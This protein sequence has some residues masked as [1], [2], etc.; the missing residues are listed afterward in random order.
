MPREAISLFPELRAMVDQVE[1][2]P[3]EF[4]LASPTEQAEQALQ[5][6]AGK[7]ARPG[8]GQGFQLDQEVK[9]AVE[10]L[11]MNRA[12]EFYSQA[13]DVED[14][15]G[16]ES[17]DLICRR[18]GE[19]K[20]VEVKGTTTDGAEVILTPNEVRHAREYSH[21]ALFVVS[22]ITV[23]RAEDGTVTATGGNH[24]C[25]DPWRVGDGTLTPLGFRYQV[26]PKQA[27][28]A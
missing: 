18:G 2:Q 13:W 16:S 8:R 27:E 25:Y 14:V 4:A 9:V 12:T 3:S 10:A 23:G 26:P 28:D 17:Y 5:D 20:H 21:T 24:H 19:V 6:A 1:A 22:H 11:A 15:H 7:V